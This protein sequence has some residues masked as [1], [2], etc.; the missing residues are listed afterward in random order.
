MTLRTE[1]PSKRRRAATSTTVVREDAQRWAAVVA[2]DK[3]FDGKFFFSVTSTGVYCRPSCPS[4]RAK[5]ENVAFHDTC[6]EAEF[7]GFR[8]CRR[9]RPNETS[10]DARHAHLV[11]EACR[12]IASEENVPDLADLAS[13]S[14]ISRFHFHRLF[15]KIVGVTPKAYALA[16]RR[17]SVRDELQRSA[18]VTEAIYNAGFNSSSRFYANASE[19]LGM[20]PTTF[21]AGGKNEV[22][23]IAVGRC[24]LGKIL[25]A[26]SEKGIAAILIGDDAE[27][28]KADLVKI[29]SKAE[30][31]AGDRR[32]GKT[33]ARVIALVERPESPVDLPLD[34]RGTAFQQRVWKALQS[35]P[36]GAT[37]TYTEVAG[38]LGH[39]KAVRAVARACATNP[40]AIA[41]PCH[42]VV[43]VDGEMAGY[44]WGIERKRLLLE[45]ESRS[46]KKS[47]RQ[48]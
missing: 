21:R 35:I 24:S 2:R 46:G 39:P 5:R 41:V 45:R 16:H 15:K 10:L 11:A 20:T 32:F 7:A 42:R 9:C 6:A 33:L 36:P 18:S 29:F 14:G 31:V 47:N 48:G 27:R 19:Q 25:V 23:T 3:S 28:L 43:R 44:R 26:A 4:R 13:T 38:R 40:L 34:I 17:N 8:P 1:M 22:L 12:R 37:A 30:F